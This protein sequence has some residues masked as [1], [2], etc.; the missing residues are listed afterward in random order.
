MEDGEEQQGDDLQP[1]A[2]TDRNPRTGLLSDARLP[3]DEWSCMDG[4]SP[5]SLRYSQSWLE[6]GTSAARKSPNS[7]STMPTFVCLR[8][9]PAVHFPNASDLRT[10][11]P[12]TSK[13][14]A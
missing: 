5:G 11:W 6:L 9:T 3:P 7:S 10:R 14:A 13:N 2:R 4:E 1:R 12:V 8:P